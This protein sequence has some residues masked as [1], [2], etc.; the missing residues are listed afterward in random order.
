MEA[1]VSL[2]YFPVSYSVLRYFNTLPGCAIRSG[3]R[4]GSPSFG[5]SGGHLVFSPLETLALSLAMWCNFR[6]WKGLPLPP[7]G[8]SRR[9]RD[10]VRSCYS[11]GRKPGSSLLHS[12]S[13]CECNTGKDTYQFRSSR[14]RPLAVNISL[15]QARPGWVLDP[16]KAPTAL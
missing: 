6:E 8:T 3:I 5:V 2:R 1:L 7:R 4:N 16:Q 10:Q 9:S 13:G 14:P 11:V 12:V 15:L